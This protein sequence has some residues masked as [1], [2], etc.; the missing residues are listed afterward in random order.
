MASPWTSRTERDRYLRL[1]D[2]V[3]G[4]LRRALGGVNGIA[5]APQVFSRA[6]A[7]DSLRR[8]LVDR[9]IAPGAPI[10]AAIKNLAGCRIVLYTGNDLERVMQSRILKDNFEID[11]K[12]S[13]TH[14]P[15]DIEASDDEL[16][17]GI[18]YVVQLEARR[19]ALVEYA[20]L[21]GL[22]CEIQLQTILNH[23]WSETSHDILYKVDATTG[24]GSRQLAEIKTRFARVMREH[25]LPAGYDLQKIQDDA[26][27]LR[28]GQSLFRENPIA[29]LATAPDNNARHDLLER[30]ASLL[31]PGLDQPAAHVADIRRASVEAIEAARSDPVVPRTGLLG[32]M[33]GSSAKAVLQRGLQVLEVIRYVDIETAFAALIRLWEGASEPDERQAIE[34]SVGKLAAYNLEIWRQTGAAVQQLILNDLQSWTPERRAS[35]RSLVL[36]VCRAALEVEMRGAAMTGPDVVTFSRATVAPHPSLVAVRETSAALALEALEQSTS[37]AQWREAWHV[38]WTGVRGVAE[39]EREPELRLSQLVLARQAIKAVTDKIAA[40]PFDV[41]QEIEEGVYRTW[42]QLRS[43][44]VEGG[45]ENLTTALAAARQD[46]IACRDAMN[47]NERYVRYKTLVGFRTIFKDEWDTADGG[48]GRSERRSARICAYAAEVTDMTKGEWLR[49]VI[50]CAATQSNDLATFPPLMTF[51]REVTTREPAIALWILT[52]GGESVGWLTPAVIPHLLASPSRAA[53]LTLLERW[54]TAHKPA[55]VLARTLWLSEEGLVDLIRSTAAHVVPT[56]DSLG[57]VL[58]AV[59][60]AL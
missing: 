45:S 35:T 30:I 47:A 11:W 49:C 31:L 51:L 21:A 10:E 28:R 46:L 13:K 36:L 22:R 4:I 59:S 60:T 27:W 25:L 7:A 53:G 29:G 48:S 23:A 54:L 37:G 55:H 8:K 14:F 18:H 6:K 2:T 52:T 34:V 12:A 15:K 39:A 56:K 41:Q 44:P 20:D 50:D 43:W 57:C 33:R 24:Y 9:S 16:Y 19:L 58:I 3:A 40:I 42:R 1:A 17:Q 5:N 26:E 32:D 38:L